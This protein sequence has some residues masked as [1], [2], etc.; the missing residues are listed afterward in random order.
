M[1]CTHY[2]QIDLNYFS[3]PG[4]KLPELFAEISMKKRKIKF[5]FIFLADALA[6]D[7]QASHQS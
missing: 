5:E 2:R 3:S 7:L 6:N 1:H 4:S